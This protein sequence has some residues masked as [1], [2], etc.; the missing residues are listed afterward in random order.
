M[1]PI[2]A[3]TVFASAVVDESVVLNTP[4]LLVVAGG[5]TKDVVG[6]VAA[7]GH[8]LTRHRVALRIHG[9][10]GQGAGARAIGSQRYGIRHEGC[11]ER[12]GRTRGECHRRVLGHR[13]GCRPLS[14]FTSALVD[15]KVAVNT[16]KPFVVPE[17]GNNVFAVPV[18]DNKTAWPRHRVSLCVEQPSTLTCFDSRHPQVNDRGA[19]G[20]GGGCT[21]RRARE[22]GHRR[23]GVG[24]GGYRGNGFGLRFGG[25]QRCRHTPPPRCS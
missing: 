10:Q 12:C 4:A 19:C 20:E 6:T 23:C 13:A 7:H 24:A 2:V 1:V 22:E 5:L 9:G 16:P 25:G 11:V 15:A 18:L 8:C 21:A 17:A 14:V 3:V